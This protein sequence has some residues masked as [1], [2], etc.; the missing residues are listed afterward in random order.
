MRVLYG[1][2]A[3]W[4]LGRSLGVDP[5]ATRGK[6]CPFSCIYCQYGPTTRP[7]VRRQVYVP[8]ERLRNAIRALGAVDADC[9]TFAGLGE[10]TLAANLA[11]LATAARQELSLPLVLLTGS[12]LLPN[13]D[14]RADMLAFD[15]VIATLN[16]ADERTFRHINRPATS[17]SYSLQSLVEGL[18]RFREAYAGHLVVQVMLVRANLEAVPA[19]ASLL[20]QIAPD[21]VQLNTP[22]QPALGGP[23]TAAEMRLAATHITGMPVSSVYDRGQGVGPLRIV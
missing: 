19:I 3:S 12:A 20:R 9:V 13:V 15:R 5:L 16:A 11:A 1:P 8:V 6:R 23:L 4:R 10:P 14:V 18:C 17:Y 21:E 7:T 22:L 2:V